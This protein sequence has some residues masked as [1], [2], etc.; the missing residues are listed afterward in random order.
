MS[1][2]R[3]KTRDPLPD[4]QVEVEVVDLEPTLR[5][6]HISWNYST[7]YWL[8]L[9]G[10]IPWAVW[11][12]LLSFC[13]GG[14]DTC[15]PSISLIAD[16]ATG[17]NRNLVTGRW[18]GRGTNRCRQPGALDA[19]E[20]AGLLSIQIDRTGRQTRYTFHV[21]REPPLLT[22]DQLSQ[23]PPRLQQLH[24]DLLTRCGID[25]ET[26]QQRI[27]NLRPRAGGGATPA[28]WDSTPAAQGTTPAARGS[29][30][31][32][33][34]QLQIEEVWRTIKEALKTEISPANYQ[35]YLH[36][37]HAIAFDRDTATLL[38]E[39]SSP[40][41]ANQ[42]NNYFA[43]TILRAAATTDASTNGVPI[44]SVEFIPRSPHVWDPDQ[45]VHSSQ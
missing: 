15:W 5:G 23:L 38:V 17:G 7:R 33:K 27:H 4:E 36:D 9:L 44:A 45:D 34:E 12:T 16:I 24:A 20:D 28:A 3:N 2:P 26:Y 40:L 21:L 29:T 13:F 25:Q 22:P 11:Q 14:R 31:H 19:L 1:G 43:I 30:N 18:R 6:Y 41:A 32:Y 39:A 10:P 8:P 37:T 35:T 42:L